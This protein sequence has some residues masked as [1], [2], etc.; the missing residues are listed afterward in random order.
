MVIYYKGQ[1]LSLLLN[2]SKH[3]AS[4]YGTQDPSIGGS[5]VDFKQLLVVTVNSMRQIPSTD[6]G[7]T[8]SRLLMNRIK[9]SLQFDR[10]LTQ[11][12]LV[13]TIRKYSFNIYFNIILSSTPRPPKFSLPL[14]VLRPKLCMHFNY[15]PMRS[16]CSAHLIL[17]NFIALIIFKEFKFILQFASSSCCFLF[18]MSK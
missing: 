4:S 14:Q 10:I 12:D 5:T 13:H 3:L 16:T 7:Q 6:T 17:P 9:E 11:L 1:K 8:F 18:L 15:L 2:T